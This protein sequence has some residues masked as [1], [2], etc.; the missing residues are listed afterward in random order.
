MRSSENITRIKVVYDALG[1]L[2][3]DVI[4][5]GGATVSLY[6]DRASGEIRPTDDVNILIETLDYKGYAIIEERLRAKGFVNDVES[7]VICRYIV[8]GIIVDVMPMSEEI[9]GFANKWYHEGFST[10]IKVEIDE[11][12]QIRI[13]KPEHFIATKLEAF[14]SRGANDGRMS[15]DFENIIYVLNNRSTIWDEFQNS[16][17]G[18]KEYLKKEFKQLLNESYIE[19]W[20]SSHLEYYE[21]KR[22]HFITG[23]LH[24]FVVAL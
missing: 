17:L 12:Y 20:I 15:S 13:F 19:E 11:D 24:E 23:N 22:V 16:S 6:A 8:N 1:E 10:S 18:V 21:Q 7:G 14:K 2:C 5:V 3:K 4:F 9:L